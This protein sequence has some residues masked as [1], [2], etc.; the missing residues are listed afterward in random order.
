M[1]LQTYGPHLL[2]VLYTTAYYTAFQDRR[3]GGLWGRS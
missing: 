2:S 1:D 3:R